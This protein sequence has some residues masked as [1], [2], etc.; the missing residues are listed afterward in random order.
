[1]SQLYGILSVCTFNANFV[2]RKKFDREGERAQY[3]R[4][5]KMAD[6]KRVRRYRDEGEYHSD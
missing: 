1:M 4:E 5:E 3:R 6:G 2:N